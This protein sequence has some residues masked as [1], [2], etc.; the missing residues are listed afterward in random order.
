MPGPPTPDDGPPAAAFRDFLAATPDFVVAFSDDGT[1]TYANPAATSLLGWRQD[2]IIG[3]SIAD[4]IHP[5]DLDRA[6]EVVELVVGQ[7]IHVSPAQYRVQRADGTYLPL[8]FHSGPAE[9]SAL[10]HI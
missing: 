1:I 2:A 7:L 6:L 8:E 10:G 3:R 4:F 5:D 9:T